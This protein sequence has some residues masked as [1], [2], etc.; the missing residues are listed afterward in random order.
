[1][2]IAA[3]RSLGAV[4]LPCL[5]FVLINSGPVLAGGSERDSEV[6]FSRE[7]API[8]QRSCQNCHRPGGTAPMS[9]VNYSEV[10]PWARSIKNRTQVREMPPWFIDKNIG[11]QRF[12]DDPSLT[13]Q[14]IELIGRWVDTGALEGDPSDMPPPIHIYEAEWGIGDPDLIVS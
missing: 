13:D 4:V 8:L 5:V 12:K 1:M 9:L 11:I 2:K 7:I 10:R 3:Y 6:T 14:E